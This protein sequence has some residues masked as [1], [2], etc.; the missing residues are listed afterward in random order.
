MAVIKTIMRLFR[1]K[2]NP[3]EKKIMEF[4]ENYESLVRLSTTL[5][6][7]SN[8][9]I[10]KQESISSIQNQ[11]GFL[12]MKLKRGDSLTDKQRE[13]LEYLTYLSEKL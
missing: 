9:E 8:I 1:K 4:I 12:E 10:R 13:P 5:H 7:Q 6:H 3:F 11:K 2:Q